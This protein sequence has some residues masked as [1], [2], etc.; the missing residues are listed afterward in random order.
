[1]CDF[2]APCFKLL[3]FLVISSQ[4]PEVPQNRLLALIQSALRWEEQKGAI[5]ENC[6]FDLF[7]GVLPAETGASDTIERLPKTLFNTVELPVGSQ[8]ECAGFSPNGAYFVVG[9]A[10]GFLE[11][12]DP[13]R[14]SLRGDL[15]YQKG[16]EDVM[17][18]S[19]AVTC[20]AFSEDSELV[21]CGCISGEVAVWR[22]STGKLV[23]AFPKCHEQGITHV[24]FSPDLQSIVSCGFDHQIRVL[25]MKSGRVLK[26]FRGHESYVNC[27]FW[28][29]G[30][31]LL[32][33]GSHDG[34]V[35]V[36]DT[37]RVD[38]IRS[39]VPT[40]GNVL[41]PPPI[42]AI[43]PFKHTEKDSLFLVV[44]QSQSVHIFS[45]AERSFVKRITNKGVKFMAA[46]VRQDTIFALTEDGSIF[47]Y[48]P[49]DGSSTI[50]SLKVAEVEPISFACHPSLNILVSYDISGKVKFW[51]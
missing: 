50:A 22:L 25:G 28:I 29:E 31:E 2:S 21:A 10:D 3:F 11:V 23:K 26:E 24:S 42:R 34:S 49:A 45:L 43:L 30:T 7:H 5:P 9:T 41:A 32:L 36:W 27:A 8:V 39:F 40:E 19:S 12:W 1:M 35:R 4:V 37:Q 13:I 14:G 33:S 44:T 51:K 15:P 20:L 17:K 38:C 6:V 48:R 16:E 46:Q 18:V 47:S